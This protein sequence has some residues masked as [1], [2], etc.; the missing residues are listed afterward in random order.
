MEIEVLRG[1][2][3]ALELKRPPLFL[4]MHGETMREKRRKVAKIVVF[5]WEIN[6]R[7]IYHIETGTT[8]TPGNTSGAAEGH[9]YCQTS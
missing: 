7:C 3:S 9:L 1:A 2:R 5:L 6:Y 8:I 4:E